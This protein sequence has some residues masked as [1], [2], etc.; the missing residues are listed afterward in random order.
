M[1]TGITQ[2]SGQ[3]GGMLAF[4]F[5]LSKLFDNAWGK[6]SR[7]FFVFVSAP[8]KWV[9]PP[10]LQR[11]EKATNKAK[12]IAIVFDVYVCI[13]ARIHECLMFKFV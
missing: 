8:L 10:I 9:A 13:Y 1:D 12:H 5:G 2:L 11:T 6:W 4:L 3:H 7:S